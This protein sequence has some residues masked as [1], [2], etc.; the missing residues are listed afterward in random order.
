MSVWS[1][2]DENVRSDITKKHSPHKS[3][4][5]QMTPPPPKVMGWESCIGKRP[6]CPRHRRDTCGIA[7]EPPRPWDG[8][9]VM[10]SGRDA[11]G[12]RGHRGTSQP[13]PWENCSGK[14]PRCPGFGRHRGASQPTPPRPWDRRTVS[15]SGL[16]AR[17]IG[18]IPVASQPTPR[19]HGMGGL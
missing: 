1:P 4:L 9:T 18:G 14:R 13:T 3:P 15:A 5:G 8:R 10:G 7:A 11:R 6:R 17:G 19:G 16:E 12:V 2:R